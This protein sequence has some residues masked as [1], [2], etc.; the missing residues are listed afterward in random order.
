[1]ETLKGFISEGEHQQQDFKF[2]IDDQKKIARTLAAFANTDG[3]RLLIGVKDNGKITGVIPEEEFHMIAG[4]ASMYCD[5]PVS[6]THKIWQEDMKLVLEIFVLASPRRNHKAKDELGNWKI[7]IRRKD[8]TLL[9]N[10]ILLLVW[11]FERDGVNRPEKFTDEALSIL[12]YIEQNP[13]VT[14]SQLY[15]HIHISKKMIDHYL[16]LFVYWG[17]VKMDISEEGVFYE[18]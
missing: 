11:K 7:Y 18:V 1:M 17:N 12:K 13:H 9:A 4:A 10:K 16:A 8:H 6:F 14:L 2:R 5:P 15:K 3:G